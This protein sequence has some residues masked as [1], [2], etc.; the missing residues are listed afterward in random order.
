MEKVVKNVEPEEKTKRMP[1][2]KLV[3]MQATLIN[4]FGML[5]S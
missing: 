2:I 5:S 3:F 1:A 4:H